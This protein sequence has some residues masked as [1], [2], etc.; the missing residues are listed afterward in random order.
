MLKGVEIQIKMKFFWGNDLK[1]MRNFIKNKNI[2]RYGKRAVYT[3]SFNYSETF[4]E[5]PF[6]VVTKG[7]PF[8]A[9]K[10]GPIFTLGGPILRL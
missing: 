6:F 2:M 1:G 9:Y 8:L 4:G 7:G 5:I 3:G 10:E